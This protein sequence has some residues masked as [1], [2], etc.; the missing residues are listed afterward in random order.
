MN[1]G[2]STIEF[3]TSFVFV[4]GLLF[5]FIKIAF[6]ATNGYYV[7][8]A[9][10]MASRAYMITDINSNTVGGAD[11][12]ARINAKAVF[13][14]FKIPLLLTGA[15]NL[16]FNANP[17]QT[18][19]SFRRNVFVGISVSYKDKFTFLKVLGGDNAMNLTSDS[20]LGMEPT[21]SECLEQICTALEETGLD[22]CGTDIN[23]TTFYDN[24]C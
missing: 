1:R 8:Y 24:G 7:H 18:G 22:N 2:Q 9:T 13:D 14:K 20:F 19:S 12:R 3:L 17:P 23:Y 5:L 21:R 6:N 15:E 16:T 11:G 10:F 4:F